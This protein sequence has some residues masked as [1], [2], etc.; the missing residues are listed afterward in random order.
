M[1]TSTN[2]DTEH[3]I[4]HMVHPDGGD[5]GR[6]MLTSMG[7]VPLA[8]IIE[9]L[10]RN[11]VTLAQ[12]YRCATG[13]RRRAIE[14]VIMIEAGRV[15]D[16]AVATGQLFERA[17]SAEVAQFLESR[18]DALAVTIGECTK[19]HGP[20]PRVVTQYLAVDPPPKDWRPPPPKTCR[21]LMSR[22]TQQ[23]Q[24]VPFQHHW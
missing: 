13:R 19:E 24:Q 16:V 20:H 18:S 23:L 21:F 5:G 22:L 1:S 6:V 2:R 17:R 14:V 15:K 8:E 11:H 4:L 9:W 3:P 7:G 12:L 10:G